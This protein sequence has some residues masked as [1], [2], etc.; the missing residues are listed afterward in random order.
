MRILDKEGVMS[1]DNA[2]RVRRWF[3][4]V[5][6][7]GRAEVID[8]MFAADGI[9]HGLAEDGGDMRGP[10][11]FKLFHA[12]FMGAF[13]DMHITIEDLLSQGDLTAVRLTGAA[14]H[15][16]DHLGVD[17]THR[18]VTFTGM[19]FTRWKNGQI[20]E[21][22]NNVDIAGIRKQIGAG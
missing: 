8:E 20:V 9:A 19:T 12:R 13:P 11:A 16:G 1:E 5:W 14:T 4:E 17:A 3:E 2:A 10:E 15:R 22:W 21:G 6:N 18:P 7:R